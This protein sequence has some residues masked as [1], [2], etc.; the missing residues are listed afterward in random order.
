MAT[1]RG[2]GT[3]GSAQDLTRLARLE[4]EI[5]RQYGG[6][7]PDDLLRTALAIRG[8]HATGAAPEWR[9]IVCALSGHALQQGVPAST[10]IQALRA[11]QL[12]TDLKGEPRLH[13]DPLVRSEGQALSLHPDIAQA[14]PDT[15]Q[16]N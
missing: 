1:L 9:V 11:D 2:E 15:R 3:T 6:V 13:G 8:A 16:V 12:A 4:A 14:R 5:R 10:V 7:K